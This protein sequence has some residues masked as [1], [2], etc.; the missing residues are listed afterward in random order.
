MK[1][2]K[3]ANSFNLRAKCDKKPRCEDNIKMNFGIKIWG[4]VNGNISGSLRRE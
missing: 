3:N 2:R 4:S 1:E